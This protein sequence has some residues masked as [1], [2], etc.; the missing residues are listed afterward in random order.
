MGTTL[1]NVKMTLEDIVSPGLAKI[2]RKTQEFTQQVEKPHKMN[3]DTSAAQSSLG[4]IKS[5]LGGIG[6]AFGA[7]EAFNFLKDSVTMF[8]QADQATA[9][10]DASLKSTGNTVGIAREQLL[11]MSTDLMGKSLFDDDA[12]TSA[13]S[14]LLTFTNIQKD[15]YKGTLQG[16]VDM[17]SKLGMSLDGTTEMVGKALNDPAKYLG[18]LTRSGTTFSESQIKTIQSLTKTGHLAQAQSLIIR[19]LGKEYGG[20]AEAASKAGTGGWTVLYNKFNNIRESVGGLLVQGANQ[21]LPILNNLVDQGQKA[22]DWI[23]EHLDGI[24]ESFWP[25]QEAVQPLIDTF[26]RLWQQ[27]YGNADAGSLLAQTFNRVGN[28]I[29][30]ISPFVKVAATLLGTVWEQGQRVV[31]T[32]AKFWESSPKLQKFF[33]GLYEGAL[34]AFKGIAEA[35]GKYLGGTATFIEGIFTGDLHKIGEGLTQTLGSLGDLQGVGT[36]AANSFVDGWRDGMPQKLDLFAATDYFADKAR[37][38]DAASKFMSGGKAAGKSIMPAMTAAA[39]GG[40][41]GGSAG[42]AKVVNITLRVDSPF[43]NTTINVQGVTEGAKQVAETFSN[44]FMA[45]LN[46]V[47]TMASNF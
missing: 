43:R 21:G 38:K 44:W 26:E 28:T 4:S 25:L 32:L 23:S 36:K 19:E 18:A 11:K 8:N 14:K 45:E 33:S 3:V 13:Q 16:I 39:S 5:L 20:S 35:V 24:K 1:L 6:L 17:S 31:D 34:S 40:V 46:D 30:L 12:I 41:V 29:R 27:Q 47:N 9:Q 7:F 42:G 37:D 2:I 22:A 15:A 10:F